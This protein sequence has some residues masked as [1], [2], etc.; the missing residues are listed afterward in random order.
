M[1]EDG[2]RKKV[3]TVVLQEALARQDAEQAKEIRAWADELDAAVASETETA[4]IAVHVITAKMRRTAE[5]VETYAT[6]L[7]SRL[8]REASR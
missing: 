5:T 1:G 8:E 2:N 3:R 6:E 7:L 4:D